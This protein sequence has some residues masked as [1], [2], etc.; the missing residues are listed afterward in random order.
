[1]LYTHL[2]RHLGIKNGMQ[3][4]LSDLG[5]ENDMAWPPKTRTFKAVGLKAWTLSVYRL[6]SVPTM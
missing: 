3:D 4:L 5:F 6:S 2:V 1:M